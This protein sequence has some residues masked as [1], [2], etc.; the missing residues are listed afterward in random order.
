MGTRPAG[1]DPSS[2]QAAGSPNYD[3][4]R[5]RVEAELGPGRDFERSLVTRTLEGLE[6]EPLYVADAGRHPSSFELGSGGWNIASE[7]AHPSAA[8]SN[9][10]LLEDLSQGSTAASIQLG[11][12]AR[13]LESEASSDGDSGVDVV[14]LGSLDRL[15]DGVYL[16]AIPIA[17]ESSAGALPLAMTF[18]ALCKERGVDLAKTR[19]EFAMDPVAALARDGELPGDMEDARRELCLLAGYSQT[20]LTDGTSMAVDASVWHRAGGHAA[21]EL[22]FALATFVQ[23]LRWLEADGRAP[24][25]SYVDFVWRFDVGRDVFTEVAKLRAARELHARVLG[26]MGM[27]EC[28]PLRLSVTTSPRGLAKRDPWTNMLRTSLGVFAG[29]TGGADM[30]TA[31]PFDAPLGPPSALGRRNARNTQLVLA[32]ESRL[33]HVGDPARGS[34]YVESRTEDL[35]AAAWK[36][37]LAVE[38]EGGMVKALDSDWIAGELDRSRAELQRA[39]AHRKRPLVGVSEYPGASLEDDPDS[40]SAE[41]AETHAARAATAKRL[42]A[43][44]RMVI[45]AIDDFAHGREAAVAGATL[46]EIGS[47]LVRG[48]SQTMKAL[49][50][51]R[52]AHVFERLVAAAKALPAEPTIFVACLGSLAEHSARAG[53]ATQLLMAGGFHAVQSEP[54]LSPD[55]LGAAVKAAG[56]DL[57]CLAG[58]DDAYGSQ[59]GLDALAALRASGAKQIWI[60]APPERA[61]R[62]LEVAGLNGHLFMGCDA[63][64]ALIELLRHAGAQLPEASL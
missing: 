17:F 25:Q 6:I 34:Y 60:A 42:A 7:V 9:A 13:G 15:L 46:E 4:W 51:F 5:S 3:D 63:E 64:A 12:S 1:Q 26:A 49:P 32:H 33:E 30:I 58:S 61:A 40:R 45:G 2:S 20:H 41:Q 52:E 53:F 36:V 18:A 54:N 50:A 24:A 21:Q 35:C 29:A 11:R 38:E 19:P 48:A 43:R 28:A 57:V 47:A 27:K 55:D 62:P 31:L 22:G 44:G 16:D 56:T 10:D 59:E 8:R 14:D 23:Y 37:F 39:V